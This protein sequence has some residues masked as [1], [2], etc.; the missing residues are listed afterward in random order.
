MYFMGLKFCHS[1]QICSKDKIN[2][3]CLEIT[4]SIELYLQSQYE[5]IFYNTIKIYIS[6]SHSE[7][8]NIL[9]EDLKF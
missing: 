9:E 6:G 1:Y 2:C 4:V 7:T 5:E 8:V 3:R